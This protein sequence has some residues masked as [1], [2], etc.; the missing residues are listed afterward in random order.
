MEGLRLHTLPKRK[1]DPNKVAYNIT[2]ALKIKPY[3]H[4]VNDFEDLLQSVESFKQSFEWERENL[5]PGN[6]G[7]IQEFRNRR[8]EIIPMHL[9]KIEYKPTP[10]V[11]VNSKRT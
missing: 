10:S 8:L 7:N 6:F 2:I 3:N 11:T 4:E 5:S 9:L 1:F